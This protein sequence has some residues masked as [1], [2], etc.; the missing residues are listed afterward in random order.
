[1]K[2]GA[3]TEAMATVGRTRELTA[4]ALITALVAASAYIAV[5]L[6]GGV[7]LTL[8]VLLVVLAALLLTP[9]WAFASMAAYVLVGALGLPVFSG[10]RGGI[11]VIAGPTGGFLLGFVVAAPL[12]ALLLRSLGRTRTATVLRDSLAAALVVVVVYA[13]GAVQLATVTGMDATATLI[14]GVAPFIAGDTVK[15]AVAVGLAAAIRR[16]SGR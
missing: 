10:G 4:A 8:Q 5:P 16:A 15:A 12:G 7:P 2:S 14:A 6:P 13:V 3:R 1:M 9:R 11:G